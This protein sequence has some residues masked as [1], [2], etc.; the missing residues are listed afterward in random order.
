MPYGSLSRAYRTE[1]ALGHLHANLVSLFK[2]RQRRLQKTKSM[3]GNINNRGKYKKKTKYKNKT[4]MLQMECKWSRPTDC[5]S[6][7]SLS[8]KK[9]NSITELIYQ[10]NQFQERDK[11][12]FMIVNIQKCWSLC[13]LH[14]PYAG[15]RGGLC[16]TLSSTYIPNR[17]K[18]GKPK[19]ENFRFPY[20]KTIC[21]FLFHIDNSN[22][23]PIWKCEV[24]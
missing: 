24:G 23:K 10:R 12:M 17:K 11:C 5:S 22:M 9:K 8:A 19:R 15:G 4:G 16:N 14:A 6:F 20:L 3:S 1:I 13:H 21:F 2:I 18:K 7:I